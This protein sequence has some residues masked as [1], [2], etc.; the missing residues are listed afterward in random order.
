M[1]IHCL[2]IIWGLELRDN[3]FF[4][5]LYVSLRII[6]DLG[7]NGILIGHIQYEQDKHVGPYFSPQH[8]FI[9]R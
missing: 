9:P 6:T 7:I 3:R 2:F 1:V 4:P 5:D 8:F